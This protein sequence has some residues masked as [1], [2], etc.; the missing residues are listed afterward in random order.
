MT[1]GIAGAFG[2]DSS[3]PDKD[4]C[5][6][7]WKW[8]INKFLPGDLGFQCP[9]YDVVL[10][11]QTASGNFPLAF[12]NFQDNDV[13]QAGDWDNI[14]YTIGTTTRPT[15]GFSSTTATSTLFYLV[16]N[17]ASGNP[18][19]YHTLSNDASATGTLPINK[20]GT[21]TTTFD[22]GL[23]MASG[24]NA[25]SALK[26]NGNGSI[27]I[28]SGTQWVANT[29]TAGSNVTITNATGTISIDGVATWEKI[30]E[31][32][33]A[34]SST[35]LVTNLTSPARKNMLAYVFING[36]LA[37][38]TGVMTFNNNA[39]NLYSYRFSLNGGSDTAQ[40]ADVYFQIS[41]FGSYT[42]S[43]SLSMVK[44]TNLSGYNKVITTEASLN[45][46]TSAAPY[47][48]TGVGVWATTT[49]IT[50]IK[51]AGAGNANMASS[52]YITV[53]GSN[54]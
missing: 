51:V 12:N 21:A 5:L 39:G 8:V 17:S 26:T 31:T 2:F 38:D 32:T 3:I 29:L 15:G 48:L 40:T 6:P 42:A 30:G 35:T 47:R 41:N 44:I 28:A 4:Y 13:I 27:P 45:N 16:K 53:Y 24:T 7:F 19:H 43:T 36:F 20:G 49:Q 11:V 46:A 34:V 50:S 54:D 22:N 14:E 52:S 23:V 18:G 10:G 37:G 1:A 25:F 9:A 33:L